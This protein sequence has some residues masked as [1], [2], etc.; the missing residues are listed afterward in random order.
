MR[1]TVQARCFAFTIS[2]QSKQFLYVNDS[3]IFASIHALSGDPKRA[4]SS[5]SLFPVSAQN[6]LQL[7]KIGAVCLY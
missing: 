5:V 6:P 4:A 3:M 2:C 1:G 7:I